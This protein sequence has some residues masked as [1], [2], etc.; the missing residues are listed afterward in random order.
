MADLG[1]GAGA[2]MLAILE[3]YPNLSGMLVDRQESFS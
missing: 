3:T 2:L 1:G